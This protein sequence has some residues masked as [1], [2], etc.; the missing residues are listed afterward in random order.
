MIKS[1]VLALFLYG[2]DALSLKSLSEHRNNA[3]SID[4]T[5]Y[6]NPDKIGYDEDEAK[7]HEGS[8]IGMYNPTRYSGDRPSCN[9]PGEKNAPIGDPS[10]DHDHIP[11]P[12]GMPTL[13]TVMSLASKSHG[14]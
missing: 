14:K 9:A 3:R 5:H 12:A 8:G 10:L 13:P 11:A 1:L 4:I 2:I 7:F 6:L